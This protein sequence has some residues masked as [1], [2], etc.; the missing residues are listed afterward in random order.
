MPSPTL[1][2]AQ[3]ALVA[4][5][6]NRRIWLEGPA[7]A[8]KTTAAAAR[9]AGLLRAGV[10]GHQVLVLLPQRT[11]A[12]PFTRALRQPTTPAGGEVTILTLGGL[13]QRTVELFWP[14][15]AEAAGFAQPDRLP[16]FLTLETAQYFMARVVGP[17][18]TEGYFDAIVVDRNRLYSQILDN[19]NKAA[20]VG[21]P[22][23]EIGAR[24]AAAWTGESSQ[25]QVYAEAQECATRFRGY[26][27]AHNLL[28]FSLQYELFATRL[29]PLPQCRAY[30]LGHYRHIIADNVEEDT[31][32]SHDIL[33]EWL[34]HCTSA[35]IVYDTGAGYRRFLGA[36]PVSAYRL[37]EACE[38]QIAFSR[39]FVMSPAMD[40]LSGALRRSLGPRPASPAGPPEMGRGRAGAEELAFGQTLG[41]KSQPDTRSPLE[42]DLH[43]E[44]TQAPQS[45]KSGESASRPPEPDLR[46][47]IDFA[48]HRFYPEMLDWVADEIARLV[49]EGVK[50]AA[51]AVLAPFLGGG[52]RF[53]LEN[54]LAARGIPARSHRPSRALREEPTALCLLT[55]AA[56][57]HP[58]WGIAPSKPDVTHALMLAI[59][60][61]DLVRA[62]LLADIAYRPP[63]G[64]PA[65]GRNGAPT[66]GPFAGLE[67]EAQERITF[68]LGGRY[69][70]LRSWLEAQKSPQR[71]GRPKGH[72]V[73]KDTATADASP[74]L[75]HD[76]SRLFGELLSQP[77]YGFHRDFDAG[78]ITAKI[79]E[80]AR[81]FRQVM[82]ELPGAQAGSMR[83]NVPQAAGLQSD[84]D[85][86]GRE[87]VQL[88]QEGV[89]AAQY[90]RSWQRQ[91]EEAVLLTPAYTFLMSNQAVEHQFWLDVGS[92]GWWERL[93]QPLTQPY[94]LS[95]RWVS[96]Q[97]WTDLDEY[98]ARQEA[99]SALALGLV[100]RCRTQ[101]HLGLSEMGES[102]S[103]QRGPLLR[104][105]QN[106]LRTA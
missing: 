46:A 99:L 42:A 91:P 43:R 74:A 78:E 22:H 81:K 19:L 61:M 95:R 89:V 21:F 30:L 17:L 52:L 15:I 73:R 16:V 40:A 70:G 8:G 34:P 54:R 50:P 35:Q 23:T 5:P 105:I 11:L 57:S 82:T 63:A 77:G 58:G 20:L 94:V 1:T 85:V 87:Y 6:P 45:G 103:D 53:S 29:W 68:L 39:S 12:A 100:R 3:A 67:Q 72:S 64:A 60:D 98:A 101:V 10:P 104:A 18:L 28:D 76:L 96:S 65:G 75:D 92:S 93:Y 41:L 26:C 25:A 9:L 86:L 90:V 55:L 31:P 48:A 32:V 49:S 38:E 4:A 36:D 71:A 66:L 62:Q 13:A 102:G 51:I 56:L 47:A 80:S 14:L 7:G 59:A 106:V 24:L 44:K 2:P 88:V 37:R 83:D 84:T 97:P 33:L 69:E 79:I 27:L